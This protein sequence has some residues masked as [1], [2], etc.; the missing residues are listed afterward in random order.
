MA[1]KQ[2]L[3]NTENWRT[4]KNER[5]NYVIGEIGRLCEGSIVIALMTLFLVF[6]GIDLKL[7]ASVMLAVKIIDAVDDVVFGYFID[8][9]KVTEWKK[10]KKITGEGKYLPWFRLT[11][12][13]FPLFTI[14]FFLMPSNIPISG[15]LVWFAV[16]Y[17]LYDLG[18]TLVEVPMNS[19]MITITDNV[20]ERN[21]I[22]QYKSIFGG[23]AVMMVQVLWVFLVSEYIGIPI[24]IVAIVSSVIFFFLAII[25]PKLFYQ[26]INYI[27]FPLFLKKFL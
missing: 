21:N 6:Q 2:K 14:L 7:V 12:G 13:L 18:Y 3:I 1:S 26:Y 23:L 15:K 16:T 8:K 27:S 25:P 20:D 9:L 17:I 11:F 19:M 22:I 24:R 5:F 10:F 4:T